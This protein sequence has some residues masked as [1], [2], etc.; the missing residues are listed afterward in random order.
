METLQKWIMRKMLSKEKIKSW[1]LGTRPPLK[2]VKIDCEIPN[3]PLQWL[4][5]LWV[6]RAITQLRQEIRDLK[7]RVKVICHQ[8]QEKVQTLQAKRGCKVFWPNKSRNKRLL[9]REK[10]PQISPFLQSK[11]GKIKRKQK[12][13]RGLLNI[14]E[15]AKSKHKIT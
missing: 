15:A 7:V 14:I 8:Q 3:T 4:S 9:L 6:I 11:I 13:F 12:I 2:R 1:K 10:C 5:P